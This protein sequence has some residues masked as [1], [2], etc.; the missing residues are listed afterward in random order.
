MASR[1]F[2]CFD[3]GYEWDE[4]FGTG[5]KGIEMQCPKCG[6]KNV[7]RTDNNPP[8]GIGRGQGA[9]RGQGGGYG[10]GA[11]QGYGTGRGRGQGRG[12]GRGRW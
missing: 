4:P 10:Q 7:H 8:P 9:G 1:R 11:G 3:C 2:K 12:T 5:R 6:S